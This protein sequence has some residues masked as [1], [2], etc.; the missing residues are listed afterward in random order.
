MRCARLWWTNCVA[1]LSATGTTSPATTRSMSGA[2]DRAWTHKLYVMDPVIRPPVPPEQPS[3]AA[4]SSVLKL[5]FYLLHS[6]M[7]KL[8][9]WGDHI[10]L[11][12]AAD[13]FHVGINIITSFLEN[14]VISISPT[15][16]DKAPPDP[17]EVQQ[18]TEQLIQHQ[19]QH[20]RGAQEQAMHQLQLAPVTHEL[21]Q[22]EQPCS[23]VVDECITLWVSFWAE[24]G[25]CYTLQ[26]AVHV[27]EQIILALSRLQ[28][29]SVGAHCPCISLQCHSMLFCDLI[30]SALVLAK[31]VPNATCPRLVFMLLLSFFCTRCTTTPWPPSHPVTAA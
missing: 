2:A 5:L 30:P 25:L 28:T 16:D 10:T 12:A 11:Q 18:H 15:V 4:H 1:G 27:A 17:Q 22:L 20:A 7:S 13:A 3:A 21:Q 26:H 31:F 14:C 23:P 9:T 24:V 6:S 29:H 19:E 8:G